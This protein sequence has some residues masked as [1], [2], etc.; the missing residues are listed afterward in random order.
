MFN[1]PALNPVQPVNI[2][3]NLLAAQQIKGSQLQ[4]K[5]AEAAAMRQE[6]TPA[7]VQAAMGGD[8]SA[9]ANLLATNPPVANGLASYQ[10]NQTAMASAAEAK[11]RE[12]AGQLFAIAKTTANPREF[13][14]SRGQGILDEQDMAM[15]DQVPDEQLPALIDY[16][17]AQAQGTQATVAGQRADRAFDRG[18]YESDRGYGLQSRAEARQAAAAARAAEAARMGK[19]PDGMRLDE[20]GQLVP[21]IG[22]NG[23]PFRGAVDPKEEGTF[24]KEFLKE[25]ADFREVDSAMR[26]VYAAKDD[27]AGD[28]ALVFAYM[29]MLDPGSVVREGEAASLSAAQSIPA[30]ILLAYENAREGRKLGPQI[31]QEIMAQVKPMYDNAKQVYDGKARFYE[32]VAGDYGYDPN[33]VIMGIEPLPPIGGGRGGAGN[34]A[35]P[36]IRYD[37]QP[38]MTPVPPGF[39]DQNRAPAQS[40][41]PVDIPGLQLAPP[42]SPTGNI[43]GR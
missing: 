20:Q 35:D 34:G 13:L 6:K 33:R 16:G 25:T 11:K 7:L 19:I 5:L 10:A 43:Y 21:M 41:P 38:G 28:L 12:A 9:M 1:V 42:G 26:R 14:K 4:N 40:R 29:K 36:N 32:R 31:R 39:Y 30:R 24:R 3:G 27:A 18:V 37:G 22:P 8:Q 2:A 15:L 17:I 23:Q